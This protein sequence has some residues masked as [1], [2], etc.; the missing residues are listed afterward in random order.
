[1]FKQIQAEC[2]NILRR[3]PAA[4]N[5]LEILLN[6]PGLHAV[7]FHRLAHKLW[8]KRFKQSARFIAS[9]SRFLTG[10]EIHPGA[11]IGRQLFIDHGMGIVIGETANI[12]NDVTLYHGVTLGG[13]SLSSG[14]RHPSLADGVMVGAGAKILGPISIGKNAKIGAN[15]VITKDIPAAATAIGVPG[16]IRQKAAINLQKVQTENSS[17]K[18]IKADR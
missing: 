16:Q 5:M 15:A 11:R 14:K 17:A 2:Q 4:R 13:T 12:G 9:V 8:H 7:L 18:Y 3:D 1:M 10:I 6:Y